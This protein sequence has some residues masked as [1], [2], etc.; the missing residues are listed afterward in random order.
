METIQ[1][2]LLWE[3]YAYNGEPREDKVDNI[4]C[5]LDKEK[6]LTPHAMARPQD[7]ACV[8]Q[9]VDCGKKQPVKP[10]SVLANELRQRVGSVH[11]SNSIFHVFQYPAQRSQQHDL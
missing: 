11:L 9:G 3:A 5:P 10:L 7:L 4:I 1:H 8:C 2:H 6:Y